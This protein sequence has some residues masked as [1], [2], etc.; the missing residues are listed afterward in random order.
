MLSS[1][2]LLYSVYRYFSFHLV[3]CRAWS[4]L[5]VRAVFFFMRVVFRLTLK[6]R[7]T[8]RL[9]AGLTHR[10]IQGG[11]W[12][13]RPHNQVVAT[14]RR[15]GSYPCLSSDDST[16]ASL[17][18]RVAA[19]DAILLQPVP[20]WTPSFVVLMD[21]MSRLT[22]S[23]HLCFGIPPFLLAGGTISRVLLPT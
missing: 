2:R 16:T 9:I 17:G 8:C 13:Q 23:I 21:H 3:R 15:R 1:H 19:V 6:G 10:R 5:Q 7:L 22:Q 11:A 12:R 20:S 18:C 4:I 14:R